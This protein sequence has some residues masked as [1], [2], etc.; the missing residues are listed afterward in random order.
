LLSLAGAESFP[1]V[2]S[3]AARLAVALAYRSATLPR[4]WRI[5]PGPR[6][7]VEPGRLR[8]ESIDV[9]RPA[10]QALRGQSDGTVRLVMHWPRTGP[11]DWEALPEWAGFAEEVG[12]LPPGHAL[13]RWLATVAPWARDLA[14]HRAGRFEAYRSTGTHARKQR[15]V[16]TGLR[17]VGYA[18]FVAIFF[19]LL[20]LLIPLKRSSHLDRS[21]RLFP[22][23][24]PPTE[25][26]DPRSPLRFRRGERGG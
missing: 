17:L 11:R 6:H 13:R 25:L 10:A 1:Q 15:P 5:L 3:V 24:P 8:L 12:R 14:D 2:S 22:P 16:R 20:V 18:L 26:P 7:G 4:A 9:A 21:E 19:G 23:R